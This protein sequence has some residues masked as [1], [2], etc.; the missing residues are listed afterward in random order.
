MPTRV[1][2]RTARLAVSS[3][4]R[5]Q[6]VVVSCIAIPAGLLAQ[7]LK[8]ETQRDFDCYVQS[9]ETR[10]NAQKTFLRAE[11]DT[12]LN[13][14]LVRGEKVQT[15]A[16]NGA[17][18]HKVAGGHL[19]DWIGASFIPGARLDQL[20]RMLQDYD[21][22]AQYFSETISASKLLCRT[23]ENHFRYSMRMK[24][25]AVIDV[26]SDVV[27]ERVD[28]HRWRCRS[29]STGTQEV[30]KDHG[31]LRRLYSYWRFAEVDKGVYVEAET[32]TLSDEFGSMARTFGSMLLGINPEKSLKHSLTSMRESVLKPGLQIPSLPTGLPECAAP[33]RP[34]AC[35]SATDH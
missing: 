28:E 2:R 25:P 34:G 4:S 22:R 32:I 11:S 3:P 14:Q 5:F 30:G 35:S 7:Q 16:P 23:G 12:A 20:V 15:L 24:E 29:Y 21:H 1:C 31:Y 18:P 27:W 26:E 8:P 9:A 10:M 13:S 19:Y 17:N 33:Y 6:V